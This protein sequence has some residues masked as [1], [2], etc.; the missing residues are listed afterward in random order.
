MRQSPTTEGGSVSLCLIHRLRTVIV[1]IEK[2]YY[3]KWSDSYAQNKNFTQPTRPSVDHAVWACIQC[4]CVFRPWVGV[5]GRET[6]SLPEAAGK[7]D[8]SEFGTL[9]PGRVWP[10][11]APAHR[12]GG[13]QRWYYCIIGCDQW[14]RSCLF[15]GVLLKMGWEEEKPH[16]GSR[17]SPAP[18]RSLVLG[19]H[20]ACPDPP[21]H[22]LDTLNSPH[23]DL[24]QQLHSFDF[25]NLKSN[26]PIS[27]IDSCKKKTQCI[28]PTNGLLPLDNP[29]KKTKQ[30]LY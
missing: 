13:L 8:S 29:R 15:E 5:H 20:L 27:R 14:L 25:R 4:V 10:L 2:W 26:L 23:C 19:L 11:L 28:L 30:L 22:R 18:H 16:N 7:T 1:Q 24:A 21:A 12:C 3:A 17:P 9:S 6:W